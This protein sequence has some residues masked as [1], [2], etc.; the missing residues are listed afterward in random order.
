MN[1]L[2]QLISEWLEIQDY[3]VK[4]NTKVG[5]LE[6][7][8]WEGEL[9]IVAYDPITERLLHIEASIGVVTWA[10]REEIFSKKFRIGKTFIPKI[11]TW[12][13]TTE[14]EQWAVIPASDTYHKTIGGG[15]VIPVWKLH[16]E[17]ADFIRERRPV[18][19]SAVPEH[20]PLLRTVQFTVN[21]G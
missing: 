16:R 20:F 9:D 6:H 17:I 3:I 8:G 12:I 2:E 5:R 1:H 19:Q 18:L 14:I 11:L 21:W 15:K 10:K 4:K 13:K 7:G